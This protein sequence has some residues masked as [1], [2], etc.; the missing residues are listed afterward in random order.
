MTKYK[1]DYLC[2]NLYIFYILIYSCAHTFSPYRSDPDYQLK[3][4]KIFEGFGNKG[5]KLF[6]KLGDC[7]QRSFYTNEDLLMNK[8]V[9]LR[10]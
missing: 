7:W 4:E 5:N 6:P 9:D 2:N 8:D 3:S 1:D 10:S